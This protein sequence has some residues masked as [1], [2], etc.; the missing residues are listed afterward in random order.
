MLLPYRPHRSNL[1]HMNRQKLGNEKTDILKHLTDLPED[2]D[3]AAI[4]VQAVQLFDK[5][6]DNFHLRHGG[7]DERIVLQITPKHPERL[8]PAVFVEAL[9]RRFGSQAFPPNIQHVAEVNSY[10]ILYTGAPLD[11]FRNHITRNLTEL[12]QELG[13]A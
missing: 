12:D 3:A 10:S 7:N 9:K 5:A 8:T 11:L 6:Y 13:R 1:A 2:L 4:G